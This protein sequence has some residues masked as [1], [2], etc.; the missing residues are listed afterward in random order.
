MANKTKNT[1]VVG[2]VGN[3]II[4]GGYM[5]ARTAFYR[6]RRGSKEEEGREAGE[7]V[8]WFQ[9]GEIFKEHIGKLSEDECD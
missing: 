8:T 6:Y 7:D 3:V 4:D 5:E 1:V 2:N 9:D